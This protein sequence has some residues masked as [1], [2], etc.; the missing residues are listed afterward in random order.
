MTTLGPASGGSV[1]GG[2]RDADRDEIPRTVTLKDVAREAEVHPSTVSRS[3]DPFQ[4]S[5][6]STATRERVLKVAQSMHYR[7]DLMASSF[8]RQR[9]LTIGV[10]IPDFGNPIYAELV[11]GISL[12]LER[13]GYAALIVETRD[14]LDRLQAALTTLESRKVDGIITAATREHDARYLRRVARSGLP[15][16]MAVRWVRSVN[17]PRVTNDD[18]RGGTLAAEHL[19]SLGHTRLAQVHGP[20]DI[21][22]FRERCDGFRRAL[23]HAGLNAPE[24]ADHGEAPTVDEGRRIM[25]TILASRRPHPTGIFAHNDLMAIGAIEALGEAGLRCPED[26]SV[27]GYNDIPLT[28]HLDPPLSTIRMPTREVGRIAAQTVLAAVQGT[29]ET[30]TSIALQPTLVPRASTAPVG[31][32]QYKRPGRRTSIKRSAHE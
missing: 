26:V 20:E 29:E 30:A 15:V 28:E 3:L 5:R 17:L 19:L 11:R 23:A 32:R 2:A 4:A 18:L 22:T 7:P 24:P 13:D 1:R 6:V 9:S 27:I 31:G 8:R 21:E 10:I 16:V 14:D 25:R 12:Q